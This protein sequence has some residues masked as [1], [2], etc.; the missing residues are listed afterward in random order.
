MLFVIFDVE[1][2]FLFAWAV[3]FDQFGWAGIL[4]VGIFIALLPRRWSTP[5]SAAR[6]TGTWRA[7]SGIAASRPSDRD[8]VEDAA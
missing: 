7:A 1:I 8:V 4:A 2:I 5:G 6:S 3:R